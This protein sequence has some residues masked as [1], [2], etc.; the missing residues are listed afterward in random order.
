MVLH[1]SVE[2]FFWHNW[3]II[4][5]FTMRTKVLETTLR[6]MNQESNKSHPCH[7]PT[8]PPWHLYWRSLVQSKSQ[9]SLVAF[10]VTL[11]FSL[12]SGLVLWPSPYSFAYCCHISPSLLWRAVTLPRS[13]FNWDSKVCACSPRMSV[14]FSTTAR[15]RIWRIY[16]KINK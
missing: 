15:T 8:H 5:Y 11:T 3:S 10:A 14:R 2:N 1:S 13:S 9:I 7:P 4:T 12:S 6:P 16:K